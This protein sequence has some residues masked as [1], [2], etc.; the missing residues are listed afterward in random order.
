MTGALLD[1]L[2]SHL[3]QGAQRYPGVRPHVAI[4]CFFVAQ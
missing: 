1:V 2:G 4:G 3:A